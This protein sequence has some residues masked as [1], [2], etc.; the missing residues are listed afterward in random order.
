VYADRLLKPWLDRL[1]DDLPD[2]RLCAGEPARAGA[3][4]QAR[5]VRARGVSA[6]EVAGARPL[7]T[8]PL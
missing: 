3:A 1:R 2:L 7:P 6:R 8:P 4:G 5:L